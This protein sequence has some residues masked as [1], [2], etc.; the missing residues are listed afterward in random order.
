MNNNNYNKMKK[1]LFIALIA[2]SIL[3]KAQVCFTTTNYAE[4]NGS[5]TITYADF[6]NDGKLDFAVKHYN[7][8]TI[9]LLLGNGLG[10]F[11]AAIPAYSGSAA[12][13]RCLISGDF[14]E[15]GNADLALTGYTS[16]GPVNILFGDGTGNF[17]T[18]NNFAV[19]DHPFYICSADFNGDGHIDLA[20]ANSGS[21]NVSILLGS[22]TGNFSMHNDF[23]VGSAPVSITSGD[24]NGDAKAD[25][26]VVNNNSGGPDSVWVLLGDGAG[27]FGTAANYLAG[28]GPY[29]VCSKDF[30]GDGFMDIAVANTNST[31]V[32]VLLSKGASGL[33]NPS[34]SY[35]TAGGPFSVVSA[36]FNVDG[37]PDLA[38][39]NYGSHSV[40]ILL[41][42]T[43][44]S[45]GLPYNFSA[46]GG[47][48]TII[49]ADFN[50][51]GRP[52]IATANHDETFI[53]TL[54]NT[55]STNCI[56]CALN[57]AVPIP[58]ICMI[59]TD[60][61]TN[62]NYNV[63]KW[64]KTPYTNSNVD[65]FIVY[66][67]D[68]IS[69]NYLRI[70]AVSNNSL[71]E[72]VDT[73]FSVGGPNGGNP[74]Y[75]SWLYKLAIVDNCGN[76]GAM[77]PYHQSMFVQE[78]GANFSWNAYTVETGQTNPVTGYS[79]L[80]DDNNTGNW[81]V[82]VNTTSL[83]STDPNYNLY[84]NG[85]WRIDAIGFNCTPVTQTFLKSHSNTTKQ[86]AIGIEQLGF[87]NREI[88][89]YPN[90]TSGKF[91]VET[92]EKEKQLLQIVDITGKLMYSQTIA[93]GKT[94]IDV[95]D[96][97]NGFYFV[98]IKTSEGLVTKKII[99]QH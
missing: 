6:N 44:G 49:T 43:N 58:N 46:G 16:T 67:K 37:I 94:N 40:S 60:S 7:D 78:S 22:G 15:D 56:G 35:A 13:G 59:T 2:N 88:A 11:G 75:S 95:S 12:D 24:F 42:T 28:S 68:A 69:S 9:Y 73:S 92:T 41:G 82:L 85:N 72:F 20:T 57:S 29:S 79:F 54:L 87:N 8:Q 74:Q 14:N 17:P 77:S 1:I 3:A 99:V 70:G 66:R 27:N 86:V 25:L 30:N 26:A 51:D 53:S 65:S 89:T 93:N 63:I 33:F 61:T 31:N 83:S 34:I 5:T 45:F 19:G 50:S 10:V 52:D 55:I 91:I 81:H 97:Q 23:S 47:I 32:S 84:P 96:L 36:D 71:S 21:S 80:R 18:T 76:L 90:P 62:Y 38:A 39:G 4:S 48:W 98:Q 64:D